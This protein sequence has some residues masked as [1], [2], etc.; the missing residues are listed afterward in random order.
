MSLQ[1]LILPWPSADLSPNARGHWGKRM[2]AT[3]EARGLAFIMARKCG[4]NVSLSKPWQQDDAPISLHIDVF[5]PD[6]RRR[7]DDNMSARFKAYRDGIA[8]ALGI[9]DSRFRESLFLHDHP[10]PGGQIRV[11][12]QPITDAGR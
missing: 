4:W 11:R 7:D 1:D 3:R 2:R 10:K 6:R 9:N 8:D 5:P 12:I